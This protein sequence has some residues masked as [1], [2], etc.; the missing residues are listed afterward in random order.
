MAD[1]ICP[2]EEQSARPE[3][4]RHD[5]L[6]SRRPLKESS[7]LATQQKAWAEEK[8]ALMQQHDEVVKRSSSWRAGRRR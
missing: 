4:G 5:G 8:A 6:P 1:E 2:G 7:T 3:A